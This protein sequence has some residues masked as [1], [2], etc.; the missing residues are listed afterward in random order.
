METVPNLAA[1]LVERVR[2]AARR[3]GSEHF[4]DELDGDGCEGDVQR[5]VVARVGM[6]RMLADLVRRSVASAA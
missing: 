6:Q 2:P 4:F 3:L 1:E 5:D